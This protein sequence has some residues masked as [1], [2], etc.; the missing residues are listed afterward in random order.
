MR[1]LWK[2]EQNWI[3]PQ[4]PVLLPVLWKLRRWRGVFIQMSEER[5]GDTEG[6]GRDLNNISITDGGEMLRGCWDLKQSVGQVDDQN[7]ACLW[8]R[9]CWHFWVL[10]IYHSSLSLGS[11]LDSLNMQRVCYSPRIL[12]TL[13][14]KLKLPEDFDYQQLARLT[15]GYVGADLMALCREAAMSAVNRVLLETRGPP[16]SQSQTSAKEPL[17]GGAP[18]LTAVTSEQQQATDAN[19]VPQEE[20]GQNHQQVRAA[21]GRSQMLLSTMIVLK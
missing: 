21:P 14:R 17:A 12:R 4:T 8:S 18:T 10:A 15:P 20:L 7:R 11:R 3:T 13:C 5:W 1:H 6:K 19:P 9:D 2:A 16:H